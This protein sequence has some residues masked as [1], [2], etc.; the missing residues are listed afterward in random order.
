MLSEEI[1]EKVD[2]MVIRVGELTAEELK[3]AIE[4]MLKERK[5]NEKAH[6]TNNPTQKNTTPKH[7]KTTQNLGKTTLNQFLNEK[8]PHST[9]PMS[10]PDLRLLNKTMKEHG[11]K[12]AIAKDGKG[13]YTLFFKCNNIDNMT[14]AYQRY[15]VKLQRRSNNKPSIKASLS[16]A[17]K[18]SQ[19]LNAQ[20]SKEKI[21]S[22]G[23]IGR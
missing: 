4:R 17:R 13:K 5:A 9:L 22:K 15:S 20:R 18:I 6:K 8:G 3:R 7:G 16:E 1:S 21:R 11:V 14:K 10:N 12:F 19:T 23:A 2:N